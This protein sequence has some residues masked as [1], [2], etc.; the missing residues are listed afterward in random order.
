MLF[1]VVVCA[2]GYGFAVFGD[3][4]AGL[5]ERVRV[6]RTNSGHVPRLA[7]RVLNR[8]RHFH[9]FNPSRRSTVINTGRR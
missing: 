8:Q 5:G 6:V 4:R 3:E 7:V 2:D 1:L 9:A